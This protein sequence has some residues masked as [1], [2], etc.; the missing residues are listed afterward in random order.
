[1]AQFECKECGA[2]NPPDA[3]F[4][5]S[6]D[7]YLGWDSAPPP[8]S[9]VGAT[10]GGSGGTAP[11]GG[12]DSRAQPPN[13]ELA[14]SEAVLEKD[15]GASV[16]LRVR[17]NSTIVDAYR[18]DG[19]DPPKWLTIEQPEIRLMPGENQRM[20][21]TF[22]IE[23]G[24]F[25]EAQTVK[26][27]LRICSLR[28]TDKFADADVTLTV[29][30]Y[31]PPVTIRT[32]PAVVRLVDETAGRVEVILD[33]TGS[34]HSRRLVLAGSDPED[35]VRFEFSSP[36]VD[37]AAGGNATVDVRFT[38]P[39]L[40]D[41]QNRTRQLT[42]SATEDDNTSEAT[43]AVNQERTEAVPLPMRLEP[44]VLRVHDC[45]IADL[46]LL[47]DNREGTQDRTLRLMGRDPE[48]AVQFSFATPEILARAGQMTTTRLSV[49]ASSPP[50]GSEV[51]R[52][53]AVVAA[54]GTKES[55][56]SATFVQVTSDP[57]I[58]IATLQLA[59]ESLR[60]KK[61]NGRYRV[62]LQNNDNSQWLNAELHG[63][64]QERMVR[65]SF[66][67]RRLE[68]PPAGSAW[69]WVGVAAPLPERGAEVSRHIEVEASDGRES[70]SAAGTFIQSTF[71]WVPIIRFL[72]TIIG[73]LVVIIGACT[74]WMV[75]LP[76]YYVTE[77]PKIGAAKDLVEKTQP[78]A[79][80]AIIVLAVMM[81]IGVVGKG[82]KATMSAAVLI[83]TSIVGYFVFVT[84][85]VGTGG[86]MY[87]AIMVAAGAAL[88]F[89]GG[90]L[91]KR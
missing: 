90:V 43:V 18:I 46:N 52:P 73:G 47:I 53:F 2:L 69:G 72:L 64:D 42:L 91:A 61:S 8:A 37:V 40:H 50:S 48:G 27:Q 67:P 3:R 81:I 33:N 54:D 5:S 44:S 68:L 9:T 20:T 89:L 28:D 87:G 41:G 31:G 49:S 78:A 30:P 65:F 34:N 36:T 75:T 22:K 14:Q 10:K 76:D 17:N 77:L 71:D 57:P 24:A 74:P 55:E 56:A 6:C 79:R 84:T 11:S 39:D 7:A 58:K 60:R 32:R 25:V 83:V 19:V 88:G 16:E 63:S 86:P 82:G 80:A 70:I 51:S 13:V 29:P 59:P 4:C 85:K 35:V 66:S 26:V 21:A 15:T 23:D 62:F 1:M 45:P 38:V 12:D